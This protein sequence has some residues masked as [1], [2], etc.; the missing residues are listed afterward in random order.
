M[1]HRRRRPKGT[2]LS[3]Q[4]LTNE[5]AF[6]E[7]EPAWDRLVRPMPRPSP[8]LLHGWLS[9]WWRNCSGAE[10][11]V[12]VANRNGELVAALP[13]CIERRHGLRVTRFMGGTESAVRDLLQDRPAHLGGRGSRPE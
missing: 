8:F 3:Y 5:E 6:A 2:I 4:T 10:P 7:L 9:E 1:L 12:Q 13:L 11:R